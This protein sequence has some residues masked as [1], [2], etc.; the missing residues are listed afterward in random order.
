MAKIDSDYACVMENPTQ[1]VS[2]NSLTWTA[3]V[4]CPS[5]SLIIENFADVVPDWADRS[6]TPSYSDLYTALP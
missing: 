4:E 3:V 6:E 1:E 2:L 5:D